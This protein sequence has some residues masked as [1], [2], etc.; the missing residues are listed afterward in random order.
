MHKYVSVILNYF[1][2]KFC[3]CVFFYYYFVRSFSFS[4][5]HFGMPFFAPRKRLARNTFESVKV[6]LIFIF[7]TQKLENH[8][9]TL[10]FWVFYGEYCTTKHIVMDYID[11][12]IIRTRYNFLKH[13]SQG[14]LHFGNL[15]DVYFGYKKIL[16]GFFLLQR[17]SFYTIYFFAAW[18]WKKSFWK[19]QRNFYLKKNNGN[20]EINRV[21]LFYSSNFH[22]DG[23]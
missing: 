20:D 18:R 15:K 22:L 14:S 5:N 2:F 10:H 19:S 4:F 12:I 11:I 13:K 8:T 17:I 3:V 1:S 16:V 9:G 23:Q 7:T 6:W 21:A